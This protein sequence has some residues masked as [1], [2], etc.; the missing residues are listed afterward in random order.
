MHYTFHIFVASSA[1]LIIALIAIAVISP[2]IRSSSVSN[3]CI[4]RAISPEAVSEEGCFHGKTLR[5]RGGSWNPV[6]WF[7]DAFESTVKE[8]VKDML[9]PEHEDAA[10]GSEQ[11]ATIGKEQ[12]R[13]DTLK[14]R[15]A[16]THSW[17]ID[18]QH[19]KF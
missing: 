19:F 1:H 2:G 18:S 13:P 9:H 15:S 10:D 17:Q 12:S 7:E 8:D 11:A 6:K 14:H 16:C 4:R 5:L 3:V